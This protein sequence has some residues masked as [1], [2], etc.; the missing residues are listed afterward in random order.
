MSRDSRGGRSNNTRTRQRRR[1]ERNHFLD[2]ETPRPPV[3]SSTREEPEVLSTVESSTAKAWRLRQV[4]R[5]GLVT[6]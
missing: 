2:S 5:P 4:P 3:D 1:A 6:F